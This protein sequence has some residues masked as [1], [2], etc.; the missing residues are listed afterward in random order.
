[1]AKKIRT[2]KFSIACILRQHV[3]VATVN[4][5]TGALIDIRAGCRTWHSF[6][7]AKRHYDGVSLPYVWQHNNNC[8]DYG[9]DRI[10]IERYYWRHEARRILRSLSSSVFAYQEKIRI[11]KRNKQR[12][13]RAAK[14]K[15]K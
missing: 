6:D 11:A 4:A 15:L 1:M 7:A 3:Y 9:F 2:K 5:T 8:I 10:S 14:K 13:L 12:A